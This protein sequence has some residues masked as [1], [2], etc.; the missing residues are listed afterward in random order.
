MVFVKSI[1]NS[2][3]AGRPDAMRLN[4]QS[5]DTVKMHSLEV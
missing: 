4:V 3:T 5:S 1:G 2:C